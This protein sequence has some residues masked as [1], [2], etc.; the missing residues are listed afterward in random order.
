[1]KSLGAYQR[2]F[3]SSAEWQ[4]L[5]LAIGALIIGAAGIPDWFGAF[6]TAPQFTSVFALV[7][8]IVCAIAGLVMLWVE[9]DARLRSVRLFTR[10]VEVC[11]AGGRTAVAWDDIRSVTGA[12]PVRHRGVP[13]HIGGR[14]RL[15]LRDGRSIRVPDRV[16]NHDVLA[17]RVQ[18]EVLA[19]LLPAAQQDIARAKRLTFGPVSI[20]RAGVHADG[21][22]LPWE[23]LRGFS[24]PWRDTSPPN[25][26]CVHAADPVEPWASFPIAA[27]PN[28]HLLVT[29][30]RALGRAGGSE[31]DVSPL[32]SPN[33]ALPPEA[34]APPA[35]VTVAVAPSRHALSWWSLA[36]IG[37]TSVVMMGLGGL[38]VAMLTPALVLGWAKGVADAV[39]LVVLWLACAGVVVAGLIVGL[40]RPGDVEVSGE[41]LAWTRW[42]RR[43]RRAWDEV[44]SVFCSDVQ[45][46]TGPG[47]ASGR[48]ARLT[49][50]RL[51]FE[52][53]ETVWFNHALSD[54]DQLV[55]TVRQAVT[56]VRLPRAR[57]QMAEGKA[58]FGPIRLSAKGIAFAGKVLPWGKVDR[59]WLGNGFVGWRSDRGQAQECPLEQIPNYD[60]LLALVR[61]EVGERCEAG[62]IYP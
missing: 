14:M 17:D 3:A 43:R 22:T 52:D 10:G 34:P 46:V 45:F 31:P 7:V 59:V 28:A 13:A 57:E 1:M 44:R 58:A 4:E 12:I 60:V 30:A 18:E 2:T 11:Y 41:G 29:L 50:L 33:L 36:R 40:G 6:G 20:D 5:T 35:A 23:E 39:F 49:E 48:G 19:R 27:V 16:V 55:S 56:A 37:D 53:S 32:A 8:F 62:A 26:L 9:I 61:E 47:D 51:V 15:G 42:G 24:F 21:R 54:Y 38:F 25:R